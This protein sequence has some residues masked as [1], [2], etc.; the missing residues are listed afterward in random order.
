MFAE[1][2]LSA[3]SRSNLS[4]DSAE[5]SSLFNA[6]H[7]DGSWFLRGTGLELMQFN[8]PTLT[9]NENK[10]YDNSTLKKIN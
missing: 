5:V 10:K 4:P 7:E 9:K 3:I 6:P 8:N 1:T 2:P